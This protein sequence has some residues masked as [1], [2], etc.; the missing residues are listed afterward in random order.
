MPHSK[1]DKTMYEAGTGLFINESRPFLC[2][3][4]DG[5]RKRT[6]MSVAPHSCDIFSR[7]ASQ[8]AVERPPSR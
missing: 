1:I 5:P 6:I 3:I 8:L 2:E 7:T 4:D